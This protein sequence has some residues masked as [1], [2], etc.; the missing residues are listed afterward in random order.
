VKI[1]LAH[2][3]DKETKKR[4]VELRTQVLVIVANAELT[5]YT[6]LKITEPG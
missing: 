5:F 6:A 2:D 3:S 1:T 4:A